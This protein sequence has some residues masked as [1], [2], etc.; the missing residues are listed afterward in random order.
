VRKLEQDLGEQKLW[1]NKFTSNLHELFKAAPP[2][3]IHTRKRR[4]DAKPLKRERENVVFVS[5]THFGLDIDK[6]E[7]VVNE[8]NWTVASRRMAKLAQQAAEFKSEH[9]GESPQVRICLGGDICQGAIHPDAGTHMMDV[10][11]HG[12]THILTQFIDHLRQHYKSVVVECTPDNHMRFPWKNNG[13]R[14]HSQKHDGFA[15][16]LYIMLQQRYF[17]ETDVKF[18]IP[19]TP[20]TAFDVLGHSFYMT[21]GDTVISAG[22]PGKAIDVARITSDLRKLQANGRKIDVLMMGHVHTP[23]RMTLDSGKLVINGTGSGTDPYALSVGYG[24]NNPIQVLFEVTREYAVGDYREVDL[25]TAGS[26]RQFDDIIV[27]YEVPT[28]FDR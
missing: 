20:Y 2:R 17:N 1:L 13:E 15:T 3:I 25:S 18:D 28:K 16:L 7:V 4:A 23:V 11:L 27:P 9:R 26:D 8:Y 6:N 12:A 10:Q 14:Q 22:S 19:K 21:H 24:Y 5:D